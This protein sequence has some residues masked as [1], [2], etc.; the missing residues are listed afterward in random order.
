[1]HRSFYYW[2]SSF[3]LQ[4][5]ETATIKKLAVESLYIKFFDVV[6]NAIT[7]TPVPVAVIR[8]DTIPPAQIVITPVVFIT[9]E[10]L[11][12]SS[13]EQVDTLAVNLLKLLQDLCS[14]NKL[15][16][17]NEVQ[18]DC[19]WT[20][21]TKDKYF[22]LLKKIH[23]FPFLISKKLSATIRLHQL[24]FISLNGIPPVDKGLLMCYNMGN[25]RNPGSKNSILEVSELK[26][27]VSGIATY[28]LR[29]DIALPV[30]DWY[31]WFRHDRY[32]GLIHGDQVDDLPLV[33]EK[34]SFANDTIING[35]TFEKGDWLRH[36]ESR[37]DEV[38]K[39]GQLISEKIR[40]KEL[41]VILYH[42][43]EKTLSKYTD[44]E[45]E[46]FFNSLR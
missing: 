41:N 9:N 15:L 23:A 10:T 11:A 42:L 13:N 25:L 16:F 4:E 14:N 32:K 19:D 46:N 43:D 30:F 26:K 2:K 33:E 39:A 17:S 38:K 6:W 21:G 5:K 34:I 29:L 1:M 22:S 18:I 8:F 20:S 35:F 36:E 37:A 7:R 28:P 3:R 12:Q 24:K 31:A 45:L 44:H 27:Y 40:G